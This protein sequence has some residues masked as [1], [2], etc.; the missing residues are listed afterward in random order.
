M[1]GQL[2]GK[3]GRWE[4]QMILSDQGRLKGDSRIESKWKKLISELPFP[5]LPLL[6]TLLSEY[7]NIASLGWLVGLQKSPKECQSLEKRLSVTENCTH[8]VTL[9]PPKMPSECKWVSGRKEWHIGLGLDPSSEA[10]IRGQRRL[11]FHILLHLRCAYNKDLNYLFYPENDF[12]YQITN[13]SAVSQN[14]VSIYIDV[15]LRDIYEGEWFDFLKRK[16]FNHEFLL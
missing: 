5:H 12:K 15:S 7:L 14:N 1:L 6:S 4:E 8:R 10:D 2:L 9:D 16:Y 13:I 11:Y 3:I